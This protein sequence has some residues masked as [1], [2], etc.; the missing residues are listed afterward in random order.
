MPW[1]APVNVGCGGGEAV[2]GRGRWELGMR[3]SERMGETKQKNS[4]VVA[5]MGLSKLAQEKERK[6]K[7]SSSGLREEQSEEG[8]SEREG[9][10][11]WMDGDKELSEQKGRERLKKKK[12]VAAWL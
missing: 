7:E 9:K 1:P 2:A 8:E 11:A 6:E 3:R 4:A 12:K 10:E 5:W